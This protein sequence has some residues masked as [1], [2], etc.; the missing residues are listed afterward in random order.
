M[1][2]TII[3][4]SY[5]FHH[6]SI[7]FRNCTIQLI[8]QYD[9]YIPFNHTTF[10]LSQ[11]DWIY[12]QM[13]TLHNKKIMH[14]SN[15]WKEMKK[16]KYSFQINLLSKS[17]TLK[18]YSNTYKFSYLKLFILVEISALIKN[19]PESKVCYLN[20]IKFQPKIKISWEHYKKIIK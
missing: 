9:S 2:Y 20:I 19:T 16:I 17:T 11:I 4:I 5:T 1:N 14:N 13:Y 12:K 8:I 18:F 15:H 10:K 3:S 6:Q 7:S